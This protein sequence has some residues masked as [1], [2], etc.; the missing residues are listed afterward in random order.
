MSGSYRAVFDTMLPDVIQVADPF[1]VVRLAG[2]KLD[3]VRRRVQQE[4][5]GHRG[6]KQDPLYRARRLLVLAQERLDEHATGKLTGLLAAGDPRGEVATAWHAKEAVRE[7]YA[8]R[9]AAL[10]LEWVD[11]LSADMRDRDCPPEIR[12]LGRTMYRW[13]TRSRPGTARRSPTARP[14]AATT[15]PS[16]SSGSRLG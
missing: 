1:H 6:R 11:Q 7:L 9:D 3:L 16:G 14:R 4:T 2:E 12:Q 8:H 15:S 10:A 13:R 5:L